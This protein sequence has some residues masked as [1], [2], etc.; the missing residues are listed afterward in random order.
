M[1]RVNPVRAI[2][3]TSFPDQEGSG[4]KFRFSKVLKPVFPEQ[5]ISAI[6][7]ISQGRIK[8]PGQP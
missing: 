7:E 4:K 3:A 6:L 1:R 5:L 8:N 2:D